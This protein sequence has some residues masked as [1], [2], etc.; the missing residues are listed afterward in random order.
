MSKA[1]TLATRIANSTDFLSEPVS[2]R[3]SVR[4]GLAEI[5]ELGFRAEGAWDSISH[6]FS[7][8]GYKDRLDYQLSNH[9]SIAKAKG[10]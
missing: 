5:L 10:Y 3:T 2:D 6:P 1:A 8:W 4:H 9:S 7:N